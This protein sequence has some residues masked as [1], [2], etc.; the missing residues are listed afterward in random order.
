MFFVVKQKTAYE[1]RMSD[2]SSDV[3]SSDLLDIERQ[4]SLDAMGVL[5]LP[6]RHAIE[7]RRFEQAKLKAA[8]DSLVIAAET[9]QAWYRAVAAQQAAV[10]V[11][12]DRKSGVSGKSVSVRVDLGGPRLLKK[13]TKKTKTQK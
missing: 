1:M 6:I 13:K 7:K 2:W 5:T 3:C 8:N 12:Q 10:Y 11:G 4:F 9:R